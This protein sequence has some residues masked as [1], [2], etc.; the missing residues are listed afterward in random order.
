MIAAVK[1]P[2]YLI[3]LEKPQPNNHY[4]PFLSVPVV[5]IQRSGRGLNR[6]GFSLQQDRS[7]VF[8]SFSEVGLPLGGFG[9]V[10]SK[11]IC[12]FQT[13]ARHVEFGGWKTG[14]NL[15]PAKFSGSFSPT[16]PS[17]Y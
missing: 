7:Q 10:I 16:K 12:P 14:I 17:A 5:K 6:G 8:Y 1:L 13:S 15:L 2:L 3:G 11:L 4:V 9:C